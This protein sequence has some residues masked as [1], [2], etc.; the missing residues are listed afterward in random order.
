MCELA[1]LCGYVEPLGGEDGDG[2]G[3]DA[4]GSDGQD[5]GSDG[6][7]AQGGEGGCSPEFCAWCV[8]QYKQCRATAQSNFKSCQE[9]AWDSLLACLVLAGVDTALTVAGC[10]S[11]L[12]GFLL[13]CKAC[14]TG[15]LLLMPTLAACIGPYKA[16][17]RACNNTYSLAL[18]NCELQW[19]AN[20]CDCCGSVVVPI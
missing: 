17:V 6:E 16:S 3:G 13:G 10:V 18:D 5:D 7:G 12:K 14:F 9:I 15:L 11:C 4:E 20:G 8:N 2:D 19:M 1:G